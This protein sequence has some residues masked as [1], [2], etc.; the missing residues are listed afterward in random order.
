MIAAAGVAAAIVESVI[1][2]SLERAWSTII[3]ALTAGATVYGLVLWLI[4]FVTED[5]HALM[6]SI[7]R[8]RNA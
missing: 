8:R 5:E 4:G 7:L 1:V 3:Y 6:R 2:A